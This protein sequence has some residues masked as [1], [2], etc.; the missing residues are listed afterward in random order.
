MCKTGFVNG[1]FS[2]EA[3]FFFSSV[4]ENLF[5]KEKSPM[6]GVEGGVLVTKESLV[7]HTLVSLQ[8]KRARL[9]W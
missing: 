7:G 6:E 4:V 3:T 5:L 1:I 2:G 8:G 9:K